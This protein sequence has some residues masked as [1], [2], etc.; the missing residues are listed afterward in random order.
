MAQTP[1]A[2][3]TPSGTLS[4]PSLSLGSSFVSADIVQSGREIAPAQRRERRSLK[5]RRYPRWGHE[6]HRSSERPY[7]DGAVDR[8]FSGVS[9]S[10]SQAF[11]IS[12][13]NLQTYF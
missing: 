9:H 10:V 7:H 11:R 12:S 2:Q 4:S 1:R 6:P 13:S 5:Q 8:A 3:T